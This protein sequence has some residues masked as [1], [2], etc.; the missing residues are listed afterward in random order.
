MKIVQFPMQ[1]VADRQRIGDVVADWAADRRADGY[2]ARGVASYEDALWHFIDWANNPPVA[3]VSEQTVQSFKRG[4][5]A[6]GLSSGTIRNRLTVLR[7]FFDWAVGQGLRGDNPAAKISNPKVSAPAPD[8]L[9]R[10]QIAQL[11]TACEVASKPDRGTDAR[12][13]RCMY[14]MLY[15]GLRIWEVAELIW[16]D[17]DLDRGLITVRPVGGKG[18]KSR[19]V[20]IA[21]ELEAELRRARKIRPAWAVVGQTSGKKLQVK[22]LAHV[23]E[24]WLPV[25]GIHIHAH[26]LRKT[27]ATELYLSSRDLLLVQ[28]CL[29][30]SDPK[31]TLHYIGGAGGLLDRDAVFNL[32]FKDGWAGEK[33]RT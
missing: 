26:Q 10:D 14:L 12:S 5:A 1:Q 31:T 32:R 29:G 22:S 7:S 27:F 25:R 2:R 8:P 28:R 17:V 20:P 16:S 15:A 9:R 19:I 33:T 23:F 18:G 4:M 6:K 21:A 30:H 3:T 13:R 11:L 24:R